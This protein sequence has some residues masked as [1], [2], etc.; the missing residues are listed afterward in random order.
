MTDPFE[1]PHALVERVYAYVAY[2]VGD[3]PLAED[4]TS[5]TIERGLRYRRTYD[6][7]RGAPAT[8]LVGIARHV[9]AD[10]PRP[11]SVDAPDD[12]AA[13]Q[14]L[15]AETVERVALAAALSGLADRDRELLALRYGADLTARQIGELL[16]LRTNAVEVALHRALARLREQLQGVR[17]PAPAPVYVPSHAHPPQT[18][19]RR[20]AAPEEPATRAGSAG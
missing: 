7:R 11:T 17:V 12:A 5:D 2:V 20:G 15:E 19:S 4:I 6:P 8:W 14:D 10:S 1:N 3:G 16:E 13:P 18:G 9:I